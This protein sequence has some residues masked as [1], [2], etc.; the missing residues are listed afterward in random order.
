MQRKALAN[1]LFK[2]VGYKLTIRI[3]IC[4]QNRLFAFPIVVIISKYYSTRM[5]LNLFLECEFKFLNGTPTNAALSLTV[6]ET[7]PVGTV[8]EALLTSEGS[9]TF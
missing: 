7:T 4:G 1:K 9:K 8:L 2:V 6:M 3:I 5:P